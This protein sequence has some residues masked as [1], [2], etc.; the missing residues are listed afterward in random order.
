MGN[1]V[2]GF[3]SEI[4]TEEYECES[5]E[6]LEDYMTSWDPWNPTIEYWYDEDEGIGHITWESN[7]Y[8]EMTSE[9]EYSLD[10]DISVKEL[11]DMWW[12][13]VRI[14]GG[15]IKGTALLYKHCQDG[16]YELD[17]D[18]NPYG[19]NILSMVVHTAREWNDDG[20]GYPIIYAYVEDR[21][22]EDVEEK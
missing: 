13:S 18:R 15:E 2:K 16:S 7:S 6:E 21:D 9:K 19:E 11:L 4:M 3:F 5:E 8:T 14:R 22:D 1:Y 17:E 10:S 20:D 12:N